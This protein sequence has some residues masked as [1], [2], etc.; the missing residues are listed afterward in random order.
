MGLGACDQVGGSGTLSQRLAGP[1]QRLEPRPLGLRCAPRGFQ[2]F[3]PGQQPLRLQLSLV[4]LLIDHAKRSVVALAFDLDPDRGATQQYGAPPDLY[5]HVGDI[6]Y[7]N[8]TD[9]EWTNNHFAQ[10]IEIQRNTVFWPAIGNHDSFVS[11]FNPGSGTG[12]G[13]YFDAHVLPTN[14][15]V[16]GSASGTESYYSFDYANV[17]FVVLNSHDTDATR[18]ANMLAWLTTDVQATTQDWVIADWHHPPYTKGSHNSDS[19]GQL[20]W[21]RENALPILEANGVDLVLTGH[22]HNYERSC[23]IDSVYFGTNSTPFATLLAGGYILD[24]GDGSYVKAPAPNDGAV[25]VVTGHGGRSI[26]GTGTH[27]VMCNVLGDDEP[28]EY[29][30]TLLNVQGNTLTL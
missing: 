12:K 1:R 15:E 27:P 26:G 17:H 21:M 2:D 4:D 28:S 11:G 6:A 20:I 8:G 5:L 30:S 16:G 13:P 7:N 25:Y 29:G 22:S 3:G 18:R 23:L 9:A 19:E 10:Y 24:Q 14:A